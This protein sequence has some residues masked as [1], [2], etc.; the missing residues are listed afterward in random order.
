M[1][2]FNSEKLK[3]EFSIQRGVFSKVCQNIFWNWKFGYH[4]NTVLNSNEMWMDA[5]WDTIHYY[6]TL[7]I[8]SQSDINFTSLSNF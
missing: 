2:T 6:V 3:T 1:L 4:I 8:N 7:C 5:F